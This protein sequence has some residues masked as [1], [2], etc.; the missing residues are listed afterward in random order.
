MA[1][2]GA[3][4]ESAVSEPSEPKQV[5]KELRHIE[6]KKAAN[7][8]VIAEHFHNTYDGLAKPHAFG[9]NEGAKLAAHLEKHLGIKMKGVE[10]PGRAEGTVASPGSG[11][12]RENEAD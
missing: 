5:K 11:E 2:H 7:G 3:V 9:A 4:K 10:T 6:L 8:G 12:A 1:S